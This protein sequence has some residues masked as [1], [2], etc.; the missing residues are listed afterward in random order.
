MNIS[1]SG[2]NSVVINGQ[3]FSGSN[4]SINGD[5][6]IIDGKEVEGIVTEPKITVVVEGN[7]ESIE[8][9]SGD[10]HVNGDVLKYVNTTS[11][12]IEVDGGVGGS[13]ETV[14]GDVDVKGGV[15]GNI[16]TVSGDING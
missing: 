3:R 13:V 6:V 4:I 16:R 7:V 12:D 1:M 15:N 14:S 8:T 2:S 5:K 10:V 11:G 9:T